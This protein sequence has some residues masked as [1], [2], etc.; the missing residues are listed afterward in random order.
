MIIVAIVMRISFFN[1]TRNLTAYFTHGIFVLVHVNDT[2]IAIV[3]YHIS[4]F[5]N[6]RNHHVAFVTYAVAVLVIAKLVESSHTYRASVS[7]G[8]L[9][10]D[11]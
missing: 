10:K 4:V 6:T 3:A 1:T 11:T 9:P 5:V 7:I 8:V 2:L